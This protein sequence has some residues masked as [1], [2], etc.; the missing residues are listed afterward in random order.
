MAISIARVRVPQEWFEEEPWR[1]QELF[2]IGYDIV[3]SEEVP[4]S[5]AE[6]DVRDEIDFEDLLGLLGPA[7]RG[8]D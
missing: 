7:E 3:S 8:Q 6:I 4:P 1:I 2:A 5:A